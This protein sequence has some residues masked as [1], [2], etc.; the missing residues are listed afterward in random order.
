MKWKDVIFGSASAVISAIA[1][2]FGGLSELIIFL[3]ILMAM[4]YASGLIVAGVFHT[5]GKSESG[6]LESRAGWKGLCRKGATLCLVYVACHLDLVLGTTFIMDAIVIGF[7]LNELLSLVENIGLMGVEYP[8]ALTN[9][10]ELLKA[11]ADAQANTIATTA[12]HEGVFPDDPADEN[13]AP[14]GAE[15]AAEVTHHSGT[16]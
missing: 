12:E 9:A 4:D 11:K 7:C 13:E 16:F 6:R 10:V 15:Q 2:F 1:A 5:S 14:S 8:A 3:L